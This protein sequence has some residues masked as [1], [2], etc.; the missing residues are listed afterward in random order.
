M[1]AGLSHPDAKGKGLAWPLAMLGALGVGVVLGASLVTIATTSA[2]HSAT[3]GSASA[4]E[5][6]AFEVQQLGV[7]VRRRCAWNVFVL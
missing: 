4:G 3:E 2:V 7:K 1:L 6:G 5:K